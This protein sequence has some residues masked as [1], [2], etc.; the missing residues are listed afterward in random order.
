MTPRSEPF[1][2]GFFDITKRFAVYVW[3]GI[4][5]IALFVCWVNIIMV[6]CAFL[7]HSQLFVKTN[8]SRLMFV[9]AMFELCMLI[10]TRLNV[11]S[12]VCCKPNLVDLLLNTKGI[13]TDVWTTV[14]IVCCG[15]VNGKSYRVKG[16]K[17][18]ATSLKLP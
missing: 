2:V 12:H 3:T 14:L 11:R 1:F 13:H 17:C 15:L 16:D 7:Q 18:L 10:W 5:V 4:S 9:T 8:L 6:R